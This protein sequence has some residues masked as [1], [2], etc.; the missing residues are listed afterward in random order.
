[1]AHPAKEARDR[2]QLAWPGAT[3][4]ER[5]RNSI[6]HQNPLNPNKFMLDLGIGPMHF[7]PS[8]NQEINTAW[9]PGI[10][11]WDFQMTQAGYNAFALSNFSSGQIVKYVHPGS[12]ESIAFQPQQLQYT[13]DLN[14]IQAIANPQSVGAVVQNEDVLFWQGAFGAGMD[15]RWQAQTARLDKRLVV[16]QASRWPT[17]TAQIIAGGNP[18]ARLQFIFQVSTGIDIFVNGVLWTRQPNSIRDTQTY[19]EFRLQGTGEVLW[20]FNLPRSN[21]APVE[22]QDP[23]ELLGTFRLRRT[24]PNLFVEHRIPIAWL[25]AADYPIEIDVTIDESVGQSSDDA[26][27]V[28]DDSVSIT[29]TTM[30]VDSTTEHVGLRWTTVGVPSGATIDTAWMSIFIY[31]TVNDEP[32]HQ[33]RGQLAADAGTFTTGTN[34]IDGRSRTTASVQWNSTDLGATS[35]QEWR[36]GAPNG[37]PTAGAEIKGIIQEIVDQGGWAQNNAL[38]LIYE[39]HTLSSSRDL[40][41]IAYDNGSSYAA[42]LHIEYTAGA[43]LV[44]ADGAHAHSAENVILTQHHVLAIQDA[45]HAHSAEN[46]SLTQHHILVTQ[47]A[48]HAHS[49]ES[50]TLAIH[51]ILVIQDAS[52]SHSA[53][54]LVLIQHHV[55]AVQDASHAHT[56]DNI[57]LVQHHVL[58]VQDAS[59]GHTADN[60]ILVHHHILVIQDAIHSHT[61]DNLDLVQHLT[62]AIQDASHSHT[63]E[64]LTLIQHHVLIV[65]D[66]IHAHSSESPTLIQ[67]HVLVIQDASH[68]HLAE[69]P[70]LVYHYVLTIQD[71]LHSHTAEN[72]DL[73]QHHVL[74]V[75]DALHSHTAENVVFIQHHVLAIEDALHGHTADNVVLG[76]AGVLAIQDALHSH[77]AENIALIQHHV[78]AIQDALHSHSADS[79]VLIQHHLLAIADALHAHI[80]DSLVLVQ[81][82]LLAI[83]DALHAHSAENLT[84]TQQHVLAIADALHVHLA[85]NIT[86]GGPAVLVIQDALHAHLADNIILGGVEVP[87]GILISDLIRRRK[88]EFV[89]TPDE[90]EVFMVAIE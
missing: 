9:Q 78:L 27:Q 11:P 50:P 5:R 81:H 14:Q 60:L 7:G 83:A 57:T 18:V 73:V 4:V 63:A 1:M 23:D 13:N 43:T 41:T 56:A 76:V 40:S 38:V 65:Q 59:H 31:G 80:A 28:F 24:G 62:L 75:Q 8:E 46:V 87:G 29:D 19:V 68:A 12:G 15:I 88:E 36:W 6:K 44:I 32:Q 45:L 49:A 42:K 26:I 74:T 3:V 35:G 34:D 20:S 61:A 64:S 77:T 30:L 10:A 33:L 55:L 54:S 79:L 85:D 69:T 86:L 71:A 48:L 2:A 66:A 39:Q 89:F 82:H 70:T 51:H 72:L 53:E 58:V 37:S 84:L 22:D 52:H 25:Q 21:A 47:D 67:H 16:D 17:P 90:E